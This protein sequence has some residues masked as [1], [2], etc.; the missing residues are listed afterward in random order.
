[1]GTPPYAGL[2]FPGPFFWTSL[3][4]RL[5]GAPPRRSRASSDF[6]DRFS[7]LL[8]G[9]N[10]PVERSKESTNAGC[11]GAGRHV[12]LDFSVPDRH[13]DREKPVRQRRQPFSGR[14]LPRSSDG[15]LLNLLFV[16]PKRRSPHRVFDRPKDPSRVVLGLNHEDAEPRSHETI[17]LSR[18]IADGQGRVAQPGE[19]SVG[20]LSKKARFGNCSAS[21]PSSRFSML[22]RSL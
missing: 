4:W 22:M 20:N 18:G 6:L 14:K 13:H 19:V 9:Q 3:I 21:H 11:A 5:F 12:S 17:G 15:Q 1:M 2:C 7:N 10:L 8:V 16:P